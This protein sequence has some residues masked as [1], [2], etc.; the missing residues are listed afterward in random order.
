MKSDIKDRPMKKLN[1]LPGLLL[2]MTTAVILTSCTK[3]YD[4]GDIAQYVEDELGLSGF[5]VSRTYTEVTDPDDEY[6]DHLWEVTE[7][8]GTVFYVLDDYYYGMEWVSNSLS[9][10][11]NDVHVREYLSRADTSGFDID[12]PDEQHFMASVELTGT[13]RTRDELRKT[14]DRLNELADGSDLDLSMLFTV[15]FDHPYRTIGDYEKNEGDLQGSVRKSEHITADYTEGCMLH[16]LLDMRDE[17]GLRQFTDEEIRQYVSGNDH[18]IGV[19]GDDGEWVMYDDLVCSLFSYG[20]SFP[21]IY[22]VL[23]RNGYPVTGTKDDFAFN[24]LDG[25]VYEMSESFIE[26]DSFYY[27]KDGEHVP[28]EYYFYDHFN[29]NKIK[30]LTGIEIEERWVIDRGN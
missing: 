10:N 19:R 2:V 30:E 9:N 5:T 4:R 14:V 1:I 28:M 21:T 23:S 26:N 3:E 24:A 16:L 18:A 27:I 29:T 6:I 7:A 13:Y 17:E 22:E 25:S 20:I 12:V 8:D 11:W 15:K